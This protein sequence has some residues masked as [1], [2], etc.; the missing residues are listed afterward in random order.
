MQELR[1]TYYLL[2]FETY[3]LLEVYLFVGETENCISGS[4]R[5]PR[6]CCPNKARSAVSSVLDSTSLPRALDLDRA[7]LSDSASLTAYSRMHFWIS[8]GRVSIVPVA[9][10]PA[11][12]RSGLGRRLYRFEMDVELEAM[13]C[14]M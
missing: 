4:L 5:D 6:E 12:A 8:T 14:V 9:A 3:L 7:V 10:G 1:Q 2:A 11:C 13:V